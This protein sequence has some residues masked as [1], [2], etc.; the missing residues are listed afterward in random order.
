MNHKVKN[1]LKGVGSVMDIMPSTDYSRFV[2]KE[3][4]SER[5]QGHWARAGQHLQRAI[6]RFAYEQE[7]KK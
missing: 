2:P 3:T 5:M 7:K 6:D 1:I 4:A